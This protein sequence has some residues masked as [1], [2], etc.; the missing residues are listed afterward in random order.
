[1]TNFDVKGPTLQ[2]VGALPGIQTAEGVQYSSA[3]VNDFLI[4]EGFMP[5]N[6]NQ[7]GNPVYERRV[8]EAARLLA[9]CLTGAE[10]PVF[11]KEAMN[12]QRPALVMHLAEK[13]PGIWAM[14]KSGHLGLRETMSTSDFTALTVDV[15]DRMLYGYYNAAPITVMP[16]VKKHT[17]RDFRVVARYLI[18]GATTP[19]SIHAPAEPPLQR[20]LTPGP[21]AT[22]QITGVKNRSEY[23]PQVYQGS[24]AVNWQAIVNDDLGIFQ[25]ATQRLAISANRTIYKFI[26]TLRWDA[27]GPHASLYTSAF[28]NQITTA[29]GAS[30]NNPPLSFEGLIDGLTVLGK[31]LDADGQP[32][33]FDGTLYLEVGPSLAPTAQNLM[34]QISADISVLGGTQT[35]A[36]NFPQSRI[37]VSPWMV[38]GMVVVENKYIPIVVTASSGSVAAKSWALVYEPSAQARPSVEVGFLTGFDTPQLFQKL[39]NTMRVGGGVAPELGDFYTMQQEYKG[40]IVMGGVQI[41]GRSTVA[42]NGSGS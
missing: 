28:T 5:R 42:S 1:M 4:K 19:F 32:I 24:M 38:Q 14:P 15:L 6:T 26:T 29:N 10:D 8:A 39:P 3:Q 16:L 22:G 34:R 21:P 27:N 17:L 31:M 23:Q 20:N 13:Y 7:R 25:D 18:D 36:N 41:D 33:T 30:V 12:P 9:D 37:R 11:F 2:H 40:L 35:A